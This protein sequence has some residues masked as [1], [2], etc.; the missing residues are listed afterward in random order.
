MRTCLN[1]PGPPFPQFPLTPWDISSP[2]K[3]LHQKTNTVCRLHRDLKDTLALSSARRSRSVHSNTLISALETFAVCSPMLRTMCT[4][5]WACWLSH[6]P[7]SQLS[8]CKGGCASC[9]MCAPMLTNCTRQ[10]LLLHAL[11]AACWQLQ[12]AEGTASL[13][14]TTRS[15]ERSLAGW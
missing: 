1:S 8:Q 10:R 2:I 4:I 6:T 7:F 12:P 15:C 9:R 13:P 14:W 11:R 5:A 3:C